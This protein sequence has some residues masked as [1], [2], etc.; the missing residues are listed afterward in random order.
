MSLV[1]DFKVGQTVV[2]PMRGMCSVEDVREETMLGQ[3]MQ[4]IHLRPRQGSGIIKIPANQ[5]RDQGVRS[6]ADKDE[7]L[8]SLSSKEKVE[9][10]SEMESLD[11][12]DRWTEILRS[13]DYRSRIQ[14]LREIVLASKKTKLDEHERKFEKQVRL[15]A[16]SEIESVLE[17]TA[18]AAG[19]RLNEAVRY[20][21]GRTR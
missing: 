8:S 2:V 13:G 17:T 20:K 3:T 21:A 10:V 15:A 18:A 4:F 5:L 12:L 9:D 7:V 6:L 19:R 14:V 11:R 1:M 16:R